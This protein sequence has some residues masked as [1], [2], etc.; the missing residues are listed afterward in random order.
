MLFKFVT[1][2]LIIFNAPG[3]YNSEMVVLF[4]VGDIILLFSRY[5]YPTGYNNLVHFYKI[6]LEL[7][8]LWVNVCVIITDFLDTGSPDDMGLLY[9]FV[10]IPCV[11][12]G[13]LY[14]FKLVLKESMTFSLKTLKNEEEADNYLNTLI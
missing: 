6:A 5:N 11:V 12:F 8:V 10:L 2:F 14:A 13:G 9:L 3:T 4:G 1:P 7:I